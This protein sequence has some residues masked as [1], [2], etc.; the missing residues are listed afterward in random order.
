[1]HMVG[2]VSAIGNPVLREHMAIVLPYLVP[3]EQ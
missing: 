1:M 3:Q 2:E